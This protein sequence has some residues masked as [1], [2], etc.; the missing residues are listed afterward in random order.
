MNMHLK[1]ANFHCLH[2]KN[3]KN[4]NYSKLLKFEYLQCEELINAIVYLRHLEDSCPNL[5]KNKEKLFTRSGNSFERENLLQKMKLKQIEK[6][7]NLK[8]KTLVIWECQFEAMLKQKENK[9]FSETIKPHLIYF[10]RLNARE[11]LIG[12][13]RTVFNHR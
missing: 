1:L 3:S 7:F 4:S 6:K 8:E 13:Y 2:E 12:G 9:D 11:S 10:S 5:P